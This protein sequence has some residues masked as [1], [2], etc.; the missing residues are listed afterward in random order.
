MMTLDFLQ[1]PHQEVASITLISSFI[2]LKLIELIANIGY[3]NIRKKETNM[4]NHNQNCQHL[5]PIIQWIRLTLPFSWW[6]E[7]VS[8]LINKRRSIT[9]LVLTLDL[10]IR[11]QRRK[12]SNKKDQVQ[13]VTTLPINGEKV[14]VESAVELDHGM[15]LLVKELLR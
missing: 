9:G 2:K 5:E 13:S 3:K 11:D 8:Q 15:K 10:I 4:L 1:G 6:W 12:Q 7:R 14:R